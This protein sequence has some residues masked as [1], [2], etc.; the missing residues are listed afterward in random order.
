MGEPNTDILENICGLY[1]HQNA[2]Q[3]VGQSTFLLHG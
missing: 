2:A 3:T 1:R